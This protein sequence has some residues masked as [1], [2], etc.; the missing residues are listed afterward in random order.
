MNKTI[1]KQTERAIVL[2]SGGMDSLVTA[3][4]ANRDCRELFF[5]H[6]NYGQLTEKRELRSFNEL[7]KHFKPKQ[8]RIL[9]WDWFAQI[10][11]SALT[12]PSIELPSGAEQEGVPITYVPFRNANL[13]AAAVSWAGFTSRSNLY[14]SSGRGQQR[15]SRL[16]GSILS[17]F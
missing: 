5:M 4:I 12:D 17:R 13:L 7:C 11:G 6:A 9:N 3:A 15:L 2:L 14:W 8:A 1:N 16:Q 10:G